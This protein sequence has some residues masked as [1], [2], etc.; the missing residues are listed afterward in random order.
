MATRSTLLAITTLCVA[1]GV[2][3]EGVAQELVRAALNG[4]SIRVQKL[5]DDGANIEQTD[6]RGVTALI[7]S[8]ENGHIELVSML[9]EAGADVHRKSGLGY[10]ALT[11]AA[12]GGYAE[13][14]ALLIERGANINHRGKNGIT[15]LQAGARSGNAETVRQLLSAGADANARDDRNRTALMMAMSSGNVEIVDL[16]LEAG[17]TDSRESKDGYTAVEL[18]KIY[19]DEKILARLVP[20][21][22]TSTSNQTAAAIDSISVRPELKKQ[23]RPSYT[24]D[25]LHRRR[26]GTVVLQVVIEANGILGAVRIKRSVEFGLDLNA[27]ACVRE[28][29]FEP[30]RL[31]NEPVAVTGEIAVEFTI[32]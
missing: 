19:G 8:A 11:F 26:E 17:A 25:A 28:W 4:S 21:P 27:I 12:F 3:D 31:D 16:L 29:R 2:P 5:L 20:E 6:R 18:A 10:T 1:L 7:G 15:P 30:A 13:I 14:A 22:D 32:L 23:T 24:K 9:L